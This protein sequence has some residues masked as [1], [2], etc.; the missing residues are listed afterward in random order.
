MYGCAKKSFDIAEAPKNASTQ[1]KRE[2]TYI[3]TQ[4]GTKNLINHHWEGK[5]MSSQILMY[6]ISALIYRQY[7]FFSS[8]LHFFTLFNALHALLTHNFYE[9]HNICEKIN[10]K[11]RKLL[12]LLNI[13]R[14]YAEREGNISTSTSALRAQAQHKHQSYGLKFCI[15]NWTK[16][17]TKRKI[18]YNIANMCLASVSI[19]QQRSCT[20]MNDFSTSNI[21][22]NNNNTKC[23]YNWNST[24]IHAH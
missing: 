3:N 11:R 12:S 1:R 5:F 23:I 9:M 8:F 17:N 10:G 7:V 13:G 19:Y 4:G 6:S 14:I 2:K 15:Y 24:S 16:L 18:F 22:S 20:A 21:N